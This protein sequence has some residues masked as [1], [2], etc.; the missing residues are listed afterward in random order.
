MHSDQKEIH[1][2]RRLEEFLEYIESI[3]PFSVLLELFDLV[4][5]PFSILRL[6]S[7]FLLLFLLFLLYW[8]GSMGWRGMEFET[9]FRSAHGFIHVSIWECLVTRDAFCEGR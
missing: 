1:S 9:A 4:L 3:A 7:S 5:S 2:Y 6:S 8:V